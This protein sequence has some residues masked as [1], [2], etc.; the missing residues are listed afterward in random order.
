MLLF[1]HNLL[2]VKHKYNC[3]YISYNFI[4]FNIMTEATIQLLYN[5]AT[6]IFIHCMH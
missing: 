4:Q 5:N 6:L 2:Q 1:T 3:S